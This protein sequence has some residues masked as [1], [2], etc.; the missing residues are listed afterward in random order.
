M[1]MF[2]VPTAVYGLVM[3]LLCVCS[4]A[5]Q[6]S[7][8]LVLINLL[9]LTSLIAL[10]MSSI[11]VWRML[12]D[13]DNVTMYSRV[14]ATDAWL[15]RVQDQYPLYRHTRDVEQVEALVDVGFP[16]SL[17]LLVNTYLPTLEKEVFEAVCAP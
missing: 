1:L 2:R 17:A 5:G 7:V 15:E 6:M 16:E 10:G 8:W 12:D 9:W 14:R 13:D 3:P 11:D 4:F